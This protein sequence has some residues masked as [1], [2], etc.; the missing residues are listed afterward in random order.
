MI[1]PQPW[2]L[3]ALQLNSQPDVAT[4]LGAIG[5]LLAQ[6][7]EVKDQRPQLVVGFAAETERLDEYAMRKL[8][9]KNLDADLLSPRSL[10]A[11]MFGRTVTL[12][13]TLPGSG[14]VVEE[15]AVIRSG[16]IALRPK[17]PKFSWVPPLA[18]PWMRPLCA[19]R[20]LV[21]FGCSIYPMPSQF[22]RSRRSSRRSSRSERSRRWPWRCG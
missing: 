12:R 6:L 13:R 16:S 3:I 5:Q 19:L 4:N 7:P 9:E 20:N 18:S 2:R 1:Q 14:K 11:R 17:A 10:Y 15:R 22:A 8:R 21:R